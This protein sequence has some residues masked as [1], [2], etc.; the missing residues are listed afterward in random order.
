M[1]NYSHPSQDSPD[2][3]RPD[4]CPFCGGELTDGGPGFIDHLEDAPGCRERFE[5]WRELVVEDIGGEWG[6]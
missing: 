4:F 1:S 3:E 6:G 2:W 5:S